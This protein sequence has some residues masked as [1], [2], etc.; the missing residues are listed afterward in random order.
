MDG[1]LEELREIKVAME[2]SRAFF[3]LDGLDRLGYGRYGMDPSQ[4]SEITTV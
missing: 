4:D 1:R 2:V 3:D